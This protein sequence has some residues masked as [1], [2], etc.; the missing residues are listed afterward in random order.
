MPWPI[1]AG[2]FGI[3]RTTAGCC[4]PLAIV[5]LR[6]P[7]TM[8]NTSASG[9]T[10]CFNSCSTPV[11]VCGLTDRTTTSAPFTAARL[12]A[13]T[14]MPY[15]RSSCCPRSTR[16]PE[17]MML[18]GVTSCWLSSPA[19]MASAIAP[20]PTKAMRVS[21]NMGLDLRE[22]ALED[23]QRVFDLGLVNDERRDETDGILIRPTGQ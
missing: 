12:S 8:D 20:E 2:V 16:G 23:G 17:A 10:L 5:S 13:V 22:R 4:K 14:P 11:K 9:A 18:R 1:C 21:V 19:I 3:E 6:A 7:A 15:W